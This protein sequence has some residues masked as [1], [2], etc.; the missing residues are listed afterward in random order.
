VRAGILFFVL[1]EDWEVGIKTNHGKR[2]KPGKGNEVMGGS[3]LTAIQ[4]ATQLAGN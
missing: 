4:S 2:G 3:R 1:T